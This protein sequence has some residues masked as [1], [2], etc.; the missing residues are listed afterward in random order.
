MI[1]GELDDERV[2][3]LFTQSVAGIG[4]YGNCMGIPTAREVY[5][6]ILIKKPTSKCYVCRH[7]K[8]RKYYKG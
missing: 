8:A 1:F 4:D 5:L 6:T 2:K 7:N 3:Y